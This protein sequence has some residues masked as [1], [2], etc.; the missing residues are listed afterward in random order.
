MNDA[1]VNV[2]LDMDFMRNGTELWI[3]CNDSYII[4]IDARQWHV[5][6]SVSP[7]KINIKSICSL[8][9][10]NLINKLIQ[11]PQLN[12]LCVGLPTHS[13][14]LVF[15]SEKTTQSTIDLN[16]LTPWKCCSIVKRLSVSSD[17]NWIALI[18]LDGSLKLY[19]VEMLVQQTFQS[20]PPQPTSMDRDCVRLNKNFNTFD[21]KVRVQKKQHQY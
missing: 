6:K 15:L 18:L 11:K 4:V 13:N 7:E 17:T 8:P 10:T 2:I 3:T 20:L 5:V 14:G 1:I 12:S 21:K 19:S 16:V 9:T